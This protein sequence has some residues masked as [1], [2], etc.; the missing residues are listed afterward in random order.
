[1]DAFQ[2]KDKL[3]TVL[4]EEESRELLAFITQQGGGDQKERSARME[5]VQEEILKRLDRMEGSIQDLYK[6][7]IRLY[8]ALVAIGLSVVGITITILVKIL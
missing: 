3:A 7:Q 2:L 4:G 6:M 5:A 8:Q 1:M